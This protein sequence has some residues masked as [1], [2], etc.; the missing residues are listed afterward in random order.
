MNNNREPMLE[1][2]EGGDPVRAQ[3]AAWFARLRADDVRESDRQRW[4]E[5]LECDLRHRQAYE[6]CE[7]LW[8]GFG[9][10]ALSPE[11]SRR[12]PARRGFTKRRS[13]ARALRWFVGVAAVVLVLVG[14]WKLLS[15]PPPPQ[16]ILYTSAVGERRSVALAD[17]TRVDLDTDT[18]LRVRYTG[19][20]RQIVLDH[21]RAFFRVARDPS[22]PLSVDSPEGGVR[23]IG[24]QFE[25]FRRDRGIDVALFE[26]K[27]QLHSNNG[28]GTLNVLGILT[29]GQRARVARDMP[30][31]V[32]SFHSAG[33]P[34]WINGRLVFDDLPLAAAVEE[35]NRYGGH[36]IGIV[37]AKLREVRVSGVFRS[38]DSSGFVE[39]LRLVYGVAVRVD[40]SGNTEL[41]ASQE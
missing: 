8:S 9:D 12:L 23:A 7:R 22:R 19:Q 17:G 27:V 25:V 4:Q 26:G 39:A 31:R 1:V 14:S 30:L 16:E 41:T 38:E 13:I 5:W 37:D 24:T 35:F 40:S 10:F 33:S 6:R 29:P 18:A 28:D 34:G 21:G 2:I 36:R 20:E 11:V 15:P 3:A 32:E